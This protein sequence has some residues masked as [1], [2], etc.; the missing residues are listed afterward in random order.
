MRMSRT[1][2]RHCACCAFGLSPDHDLDMMPFDSFRLAPLLFALQAGLAF[3]APPPAN[4]IDRTGFDTSVRLQ[5][6]LFGAV[7]GRWLKDTP[8]PADKAS[9]GSFIMLRD[10]SDER[11]RGIAE[12][13]AKNTGAAPGSIE[14]KI[15]SYYRSH[16][17]EAAIDRAGLAPL[18]PWFSEVD[19]LKTKADLAALMGRLQGIA[20]VPVPLAVDADPKEPGINRL[21]TWQGG[22]G[23]P[24]R[25]YYSGTEDRMLRA[26]GAYFVYLSA[27]FQLSGDADATR[28]AETVMALETRLAALQWSR[29]Q[30]RDAIKTYNPMTVAAL[31]KS[32]P[33]FDWQR[34]LVAAKL[35]VI[36][37]LSVSQPSYVQGFGRL[38]AETPM[39]TWRLYLRARLLDGSAGVLPK[40]FRDA[41]FAFRGKALQ[42]LE[43]PKPRWQDGT[44]SLNSA[45]GEGVGQVY[46]A[47]Y[48]PPDHKARMQQ[49][50]A[51]LLAA[52]GQSI[53]TLSW[54]SAP[55][56]ARAKEKLGKYMTKIGYP[57][58]WRDYSKLKIRDGDA[59][60][61]ALRAGR[62]EYE[63]SAAKA[64]QPVDRSEW[65]MS[66]QT[67]NAYYNPS[68][69]E[70]VFPAAILQPPFFDM[71]ADDA[72][73]YGG[74]GAVIGHEISHGFDDQGSE[75]DGDGK[76]DNWWTE[77]DRK[78]F[79]A[80][81]SQLVAQYA[82]Y[83]PVPGHPL[84]GEL[85]LGENIADLS[86]LQIAFKAY[87]IA[88]GGKDAP[89]IDGF[90]GDQRFF[91]GWAQVW[92]D[93]AREAR[94]LQL[95]TIDPH[96]PA[97]FRADGAAVNHDG[98]QQAFGTKPGDK[99][100]K[101]SEQR[102]RIW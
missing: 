34:N 101:P 72:I 59:L 3:S 26:R 71:A 16:L 23:L 62:F 29:V 73:N 74:I 86:G 78:A 93:K 48:F 15:G 45:L 96:S 42:G 10:K 14:Q 95:L 51:N 38:V 83:E 57:D 61:N 56:K 87:H 67:V 8:I 94:T 53:D 32:A 65:G 44:A 37:R 40:P 1:L 17:D 35:P 25:D 18:A 98:F 9:F 82:A 47:K 88:L 79:K 46:V 80:L 84:N 60:G 92:R 54:M 41:S 31:A 12:E 68:F 66:P 39:A 33:G 4:G 85:T 52:Y 55:T 102:I 64:G 28:S 21:A 58:K 24:D 27:L 30:N 22:L 20:S 100:W 70:I 99:M 5:D 11:V 89:V 13:L 43:S 2:R 90:S 19:A 50:V 75:Y 69:N 6:D 77:A 76:L 97:R 91:I 36:D 63:R 49:L 81:T 7:N